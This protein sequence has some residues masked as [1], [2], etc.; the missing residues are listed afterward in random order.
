MKFDNGRRDFVAYQFLYDQDPIITM[1][2][3]AKSIV[4]GGLLVDVSG[5]RFNLTQNASLHF[6]NMHNRPFGAR[7]FVV[8][9]ERMKCSTPN[10]YYKNYYTYVF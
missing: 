3:R 7:C 8:S 4:S 5:S 10:V 2:S 6:S 9:N 1:I